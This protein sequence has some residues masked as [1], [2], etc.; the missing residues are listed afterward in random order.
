MLINWTVISGQWS[1]ELYCGTNVMVTPHR[2]SKTIFVQQN[3]PLGYHQFRKLGLF[4]RDD[5]DEDWDTDD[6]SDCS[7]ET[8]SDSESHDEGDD[9]AA[10]ERDDIESRVNDCIS[11]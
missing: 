11:Q 3:T 10:A 5:N 2:V 6:C 8:I 7:W 4:N 1:A 9:E